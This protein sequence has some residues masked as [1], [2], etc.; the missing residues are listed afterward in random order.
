MTGATDGIGKGYAQVLAEKGL[1]VLLISRTQSRLDETAEEIRTI[2]YLI[3]VLST[4][5][6]HSV[7]C[8]RQNLP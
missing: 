4:N 3:T 5:A 1:N 2:Q 7:E 6:L 8:F